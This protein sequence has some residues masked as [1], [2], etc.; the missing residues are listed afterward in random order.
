[1]LEL[2]PDS[3]R[4]HR[5][6][7]EAVLRTGPDVIAAVGAFVPAFAATGTG[8]AT[9]V[10]GERAAD[11]APALRDLVQEGDVVLLKGSRGM[12]LETLLETLWPGTAAEGA[13]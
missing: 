11:V 10:T 2:G 12:R 4:L 5:E 7:A 6:S 3:D 13:H 1:M 8:G 9:L